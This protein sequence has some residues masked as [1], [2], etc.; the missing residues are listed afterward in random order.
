MRCP[1]FADGTFHVVYN[2]LNSF[3]YYPPATRGQSLRLSPAQRDAG[4]VAILR[5]WRRILRRRG[6]LVLDLSNRVPLI[7]IVRRSPRV[8]YA[9]GGYEAVEE[10]DWNP[11]DECL[12]N[13]TLWRWQLP[14]MQ[15]SARD[16]TPRPE[17]GSER[18]GYRVRLY[19]PT[20]I[21]SLL[22][23]AGF[24]VE[25]FFG[26]FTSSDFDSRRSDRMIVI[27]RRD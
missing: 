26:D 15:S 5:E 12:R 4:D 6:R 17:R 19:T 14:S 21:R 25:Q 23:R 18:A 16:T 8:R 20:Q 1:P 13:R 7:Q 9:G 24:A 22:H 27:A 3:G 11:E 2:L 10:F